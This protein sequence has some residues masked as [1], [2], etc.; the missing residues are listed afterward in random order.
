MQLLNKTRKDFITEDILSLNTES[1]GIYRLIMKSGSDNFRESA[2]FD[3][4]KKLKCK[5]KIYIYEPATIVAEIEGCKVI[6][7][8]DEF[9]ELS[10]VIVTNRMTD[11]LKSVNKE[12]YT[13][14]IFEEN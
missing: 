12:I 2:I 7:D 13:R 6:K 14:D 10:D 4:I 1:V 11:E 9:I 8:F 5:R 3:I